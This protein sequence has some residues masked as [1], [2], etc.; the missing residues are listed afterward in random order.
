MK[1]TRSK[2]LV[3]LT[4]W[5]LL[6]SILVNPAMAWPPPCPDCYDWDG[7]NCIPKTPY[8][9][10]DT[11]IT[12]VSITSPGDGDVFC[13]GSN[14]NVSCSTSTDSDIYHHCVD[15]VW[16]EEPVDDPITHTWSG[17]GTFDPATGT[18]ST[19]T[20]SSSA[21]SKTI[22]ITASDSPKYNDTDVSDSISVIVVEVESL[23][24]DEGTELDDGDGDP[25]TKLF[26]VC[27]VPPS[28]PST[29][30]VTATPNPSVAEE[31]LPDCWTLTGG[32][33]KLTRT[34]DKTTAGTTVITCT[35]GSS[36]KTTTIY[37]F[38]VESITG[39]GELYC[40]HA[41]CKETVTA[42]L[43]NNIELPAGYSITWGGDA[44][45]SNILG[46]TATAKFA[47]HIGK[48]KK[49]TAKVG[50]QD[51]P[52]ESAPPFTVVEHTIVTAV[53]GVTYNFV[54]ANPGA[55][56]GITA[57][58]PIVVDITAYF[59]HP[60]HTWECKVTT[61]TSEIQQGS[62]LPAGVSE[63]SVAAATTEAIYRKMVADLLAYGEGAG[64]QWYMVAAV[65]AHETV[66][67]DDWQNGPGG[68]GNNGCFATFQPT[69][70][71]LS[72]PYAD[73]TCENATQART[74]IMALPAYTSA[75]S[76]YITC[77]N[78]V[79][80]DP[81]SNHPGCDARTYAA[82]ETVTIPMINALDAHAAAQQPPWTR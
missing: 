10:Q 15:N 26:V 31:D 49:I 68:T 75:Y 52:A 30:T 21:G 57:R 76:T 70:E 56:Y 59:G 8:Y 74:A 69:V 46:R 29:L 9:T 36:S 72:V 43:T 32:T 4:A 11:V 55:N 7:Y 40:S 61:S 2:C 37:I 1:R 66:H 44:T 45:F 13:I 51:P 42:V 19:F 64:V 81:A 38:K 63:A 41:D 16:T 18:S 22:T 62:H 25:N 14:I 3:F 23:L 24:P 12:P 35:A 47:G 28:P 34:V 78:A 80:N 67:S 54:W 5:L 82:E 77:G 65:Q 48:N 27:I 33:G 6:L 20:P 58:G 71:A 53:T 79:W 39:L 60:S 50:T 17:S 73:G